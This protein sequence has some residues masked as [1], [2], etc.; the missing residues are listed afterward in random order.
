M[1]SVYAEKR[2]KLLQETGVAGLHVGNITANS[3]PN[4]VVFLT[5]YQ[6]QSVPCACDNLKAIGL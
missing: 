6:N 5:A 4:K 1:Y 2:P 3:T